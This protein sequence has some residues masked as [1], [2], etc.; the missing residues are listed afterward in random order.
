MTDWVFGIDGGGTSSRLRAESVDGTVLYEGSGG[1][2]NLNSNAADAV[3]ATLGALISGALAAGLDPRRCGA[4]FIGSAGVD[5]A[6]DRSSLAGAMRAAF[7]AAAAEAGAAS[8]VASAAR[9]GASNDAEPALV[10]ALGD[11]EGFLLVA[12]TGSIAF[13]RTAAGSTYRAGGWGHFLGDEGSAFWVAFEAVKR[14]IRSMEGRDLPSGL[15]GEACAY[16]GLREPAEF[17]P[18]AYWDFDKAR[19]AAFAPRVAAL[20]EAGDELAR[21]IMD[22]AAL[23]L[24]ALVESVY[25]RL[26]SEMSRTRLALHGGLIRKNAALRSAVAARIG[27]RLPG[28][29]LVE[30]AGDAQ[31]GAC[32]LARELLAR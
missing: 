17:I 19:I 8:D 14:G 5:L 7:A 27:E 21:S 23:E 20:A 13:G 28:V 16:F 2:T 24:A 25:A 4:G 6:V 12:G 26:S 32:A 31:T 15:I 30:P 11:L 3:T 22:G 29:E 9:F 1:S 10:G 18:F